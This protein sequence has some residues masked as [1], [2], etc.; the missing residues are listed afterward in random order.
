MTRKEAEYKVEV[1]VKD[2]CKGFAMPLN[3][4]FVEALMVII[5]PDFKTV[6]RIFYS[7]ANSYN[8]LVEN[9]PEG[10]HSFGSEKLIGELTPVNKRDEE[11]SAEAL[12][13]ILT[14]LTDVDRRLLSQIVERWG[15]LSD[16]LKRAVLAVVGSSRSS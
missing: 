14:N 13:H 15:G 9:Q 1:V 4:E 3:D 2:Y 6:K 12:T 11:L 10:S 8:R 16:E 7:E 5:N